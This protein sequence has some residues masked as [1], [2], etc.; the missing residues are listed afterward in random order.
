MAGLGDMNAGTLGYLVTGDRVKRTP[1]EKPFGFRET[2][3]TTIRDT[4]NLERTTGGATGVSTN[5]AIF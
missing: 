2:V 3:N 5:P 1:F 4:H